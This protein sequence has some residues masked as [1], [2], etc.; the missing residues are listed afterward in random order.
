M[1]SLPLLPLALAG[2]LVT[3]AWLW[4]LAWPRTQR[5][6]GLLALADLHWRDFV[7]LVTRALCERRGLQPLRD[8][9]EQTLSPRADV[10]L[11]DGNGNTWLVACKHGLAY[12]I[13]AAAINELGAAARLSGA[14]GGILV[15]EGCLDS[16]GAAAAAK[17]DVDVV[18]GKRLWPLLAPYLPADSR[19][20]VGRTAR[21]QALRRTALA[22]LAWAALG[23]LAACWVGAPAL[24][25]PVPLASAAAPAAHWRG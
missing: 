18:E 20:R 19:A 22:A 7:A 16:A 9:G 10:L 14:R 8:D 11:G 1:V 17:Q 3:A 6:L 25:V 23:V 4:L 12:R 24:P 13:G 21:R 2:F 15:T 5:R